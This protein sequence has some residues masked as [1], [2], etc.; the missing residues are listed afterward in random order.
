MKYQFNV[1]VGFTA[2][3]STSMITG[4]KRS[5]EYYHATDL[6]AFALLCLRTKA[7]S[8]ME[9]ILMNK[10]YFLNHSD[11]VPGVGDAYDRSLFLQ[12][13]REW[14]L[15]F[16]TQILNGDYGI[17]YL[18]DGLYTI[19]WDKLQASTDELRDLVY[20]LG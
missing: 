4:I 3:Q 20:D 13:D 7:Y 11:R 2:Q 1:H 16:L 10:R 9:Y 18:C 15:P 6:A 12:L 14:H 19:D 17:A 8:D 5:A